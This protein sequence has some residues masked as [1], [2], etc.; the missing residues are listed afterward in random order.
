MRINEFLASASRGRTSM[1]RR[2]REAGA[3]FVKGATSRPMGWPCWAAAGC[4]HGRPLGAA[5]S[6]AAQRRTNA[7][8]LNRTR[9]KKDITYAP[10]RPAG[11]SSASVLRRTWPQ[12]GVRAGASSLVSP[13]RGR[14]GNPAPSMPTLGPSLS[15]TSNALIALRRSGDRAPDSLALLLLAPLQELL[16][17]AL[18]FGLVVGG[19]TRRL[20]AIEVGLGARLRGGLGDQGLRRREAGPARDR[21]GEVHI[22]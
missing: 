3:A 22:L 18:L 12:V 14:L 21:P 9:R 1:G 15:P 10:A 16:E 5:S 19:G 20:G 6:R 2:T 8:T 4:C 7:P 13:R 11:A 17:Q